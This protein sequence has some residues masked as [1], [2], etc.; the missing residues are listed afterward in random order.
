MATA[1]H[2]NPLLTSTT[3]AGRTT[4][5]M[6]PRLS[7]LLAASLLVPRPCAL[8][9]PIQDSLIN[10]ALQELLQ[11][12][13]PWEIQAHQPAGVGQRP[14]PDCQ[15]TA[16]VQPEEQEA[17]GQ[18]IA[19]VDGD[20]QPLKPQ[21]AADAPAAQQLSEERHASESE[22]QL[23]EPGSALPASAAQK[24]SSAASPGLHTGQAAVQ[25]P[26]A[27]RQPS[28]VAALGTTAAASAAPV[29]DSLVSQALQELLQAARP[30]E[31]QVQQPS[32]QAQQQPQ[33]P[34]AHLQPSQ[35]QQACIAE[36]TTEP[37]QPQ[38]LAGLPES[39]EISEE[40]PASQGKPKQSE[41]SSVLP[42][43]AA[44]E[45]TP[46]ASWDLGSGQAALQATPAAGMQASHDAA[47][48]STAAPSAVPSPA[49][50][51]EQA[52][53]DAQP[54]IQVAAPLEMSL[55]HASIAMPSQPAPGRPASSASAEPAETNAAVHDSRP[56]PETAGRPQSAG[57]TAV[58]H[59]LR[60]PGLA[61]LDSASSLQLSQPG[62]PVAQA[63]SSPAQQPSSLQP[64]RPEGNAVDHQV[65]A[66]AEAVEA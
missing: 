37:L 64:A 10:Q 48:G 26:A 60:T 38:Q 49:K 9:A 22:N 13:R 31:L 24:P 59:R 32:G 42:A 30:W 55:S 25:V 4:Q 6:T 39:Q 40:G 35:A 27:R 52:S 62:P 29:E 21:Q 16:G 57:R 54:A 44:L 65:P 18:H 33:P 1:A 7:P 50:H 41:P 5:P 19:D 45:T 63:P 8:V 3:D 66:A 36:D 61:H 23:S 47:L 20:A 34:A 14:Q 15:F 56:A 11:A 28:L 53:A 58:Q 43:S 17:Q 46:A 12:A 2:L 51:T